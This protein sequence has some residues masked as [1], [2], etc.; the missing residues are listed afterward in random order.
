MDLYSQTRVV[1]ESSIL[2]YKSLRETVFHHL[3]GALAQQ[4]LYMRAGL[5]ETASLT[6]CVSLVNALTFYLFFI[7]KIGIKIAILIGDYQK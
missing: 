6:S 5:N 4:T 7:C 3:Q 2:A 1:Q